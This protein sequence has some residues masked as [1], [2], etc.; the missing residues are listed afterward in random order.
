MATAVEQMILSY[1]PT[2]GVTTLQASA[3]PDSL[4]RAA[5]AVFCVSGLPQEDIDGVLLRLSVAGVRHVAIHTMG[6]HLMDLPKKKHGMR[7]CYLPVGETVQDFYQ[8]LGGFLDTAGLVS[9]QKEPSPP[10]QAAASCAALSGVLTA[11]QMEV[12]ELLAKG[13]SQK[14]CAR[15]LG[16]SPNTVSSH[17]KDIHTRLGVSNTAQ[18]VEVYFRHR[19]LFQTVNLAYDHG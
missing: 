5:C 9:N 13:L 12:I 6:E 8:A 16:I 11:R 17:I 4:P 7:F 18:A 19:G 15:A 1:A 2:V 14:R 10:S 3:L